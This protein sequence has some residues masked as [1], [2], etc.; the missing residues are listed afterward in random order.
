MDIIQ[1]F[2]A[3][4]VVGAIHMIYRLSIRVSA[5]EEYR[6]GTVGAGSIG[7]GNGA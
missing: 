5:L 4:T 1:I 6:S 3:A 2:L 7:L